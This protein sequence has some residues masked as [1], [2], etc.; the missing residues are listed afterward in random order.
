[1][2]IFLGTELMAQI[3]LLGSSHTLRNPHTLPSPVF[4][5]RTWMSVS[6]EEGVKGPAVQARAAA[7]T[8]ILGAW[9]LV[10]SPCSC[11]DT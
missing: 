4:S 11:I 7:P 8:L 6:E 1:M 3:A 5:L 10:S 9:A 2:F